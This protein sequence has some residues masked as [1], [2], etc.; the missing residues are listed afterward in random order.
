MYIGYARVSTQNQSFSLQLDALQ[1]AGC[2]KVFVERPLASSTIGPSSRRPST[3]G[4][5][6]I[7]WWSGSL[8]G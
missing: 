2:A 7:Y 6:A 3:A 4:G 1:A 5:S 8:T